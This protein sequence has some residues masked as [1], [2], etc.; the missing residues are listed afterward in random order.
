[1][2]AIISTMHQDDPDEPSEH[3]LCRW[4]GGLT[5]LEAFQ[6][7]T[8]VEAMLA[9]QII[10]AHHGI[11]ECHYRAMRLDHEEAL[12]VKLRANVV[13]LTRAQDINMRAL[14]RRQAKPVPPPLP[15][16]S[17]ALDWALDAE[18]EGPSRETAEAAM[19]GASQAPN[20]SSPGS[21]PAVQA[22]AQGK[23]PTGQALQTNQL[24]PATRPAIVIPQLEPKP[25]I[26]KT[27]IERRVAEM[28][29]EFNERMD[30]ERGGTPQ[31]WYARQREEV[32]QRKEAEAAAK[33]A[34]DGTTMPPPETPTR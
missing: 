3:D 26:D 18:A 33:A 23:P 12:A 22:P 21:G 28:E 4:S 14:E 31:E 24:P 1:M 30:R 5:L 15:D 7:R 32:R 27:F 8:P 13:G 17:V 29:K 16:V 19:P 25:P 34:A 11:M 9:A 20:P 6:P 2:R 10:A